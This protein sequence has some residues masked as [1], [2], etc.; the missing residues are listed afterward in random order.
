M[1][2]IIFLKFADNTYRRHEAEIISEYQKL[3]GTRRE[4]PISEIAVEKCG[5]YLPDH[6]RYEYLLNLPEEKNIAKALK[7][8]MK[9][10]EEYKPELEGAL[11][12]DEY[13]ALTK[14]E[15]TRTLPNQLFKTFSDI[16][17]GTSG[18]L[19]GQIY[20]YFLAEFARSEGQ[21]SENSSRLVLWCA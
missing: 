21:R 7:E 5:F 19:F 16:P 2:G 4:K 8:A 15:Q 3:K 14:T 9:A 11:P 18:D 6:A 12:K 13:F 20:E 10:V 17:A 1:L